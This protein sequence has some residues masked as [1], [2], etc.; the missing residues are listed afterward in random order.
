MEENR[1]QYLNNCHLYIT[2]FLINDCILFQAQSDE[3][4]VTDEVPVS[5][6][7][8]DDFMTEFFGEVSDELICCY[9]VLFP[10][11][12]RSSTIESRLNQASTRSENR[13]LVLLTRTMRDFFSCFF[14]RV[15][16]FTT[17]GMT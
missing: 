14:P 6:G 8:P 13:S 16:A 2:L 10:A 15:R 12:V 4:D 5:V 7:A 9:G 17:L 11:R 1:A 3:D